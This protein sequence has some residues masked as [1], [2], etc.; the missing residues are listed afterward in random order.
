MNEESICALSKKCA[1]L[2]T[3]DKVDDV[4]RQCA[5]DVFDS[6]GYGGSEQTYHAALFNRLCVEKRRVECAH[7]R[8]TVQSE[9][10]AP[11]FASDEQRVPCGVMRSDIVLQWVPAQHNK[12]GRK[13]SHSVAFARKMIIELKATKTAL[14]SGAALQLMC[15]IKSYRA[16]RGLLCNFTQN[17]PPV[18]SEMQR[19]RPLSNAKNTLYFTLDYRNE[20]NCAI[21]SVYNSANDS[22]TILLPKVE[23]YS[24]NVTHKRSASNGD[25]VQAASITTPSSGKSG[26]L[27]RHTKPSLQ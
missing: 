19:L 23:F 3:W 16:E 2:M 13:R 20:Q 12:S 4:V 21:T 11:I 8:C 10:T 7:V 27:P 17:C 24:L 5:Q 1:K 6:I 15:Y 18:H 22:N 25:A 26:M 14:T 9:T